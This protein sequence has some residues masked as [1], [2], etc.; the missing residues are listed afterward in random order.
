MRLSLLLLLLLSFP[1]LAQTPDTI[2][3]ATYN[4]LNYPGSTASERNPYF[5]TVMATMHPDILVVQEMTSAAGVQM[6]L[7]EVLNTITPHRFEAAE[8]LDGPDSDNSF[9]YDTSKVVYLGAHYIATELRNIAEYRFA[10][11]QSHDTIR[12]FS[13]HLKSDD[14]PADQDQRSRETALIR[15]RM[16]TV[17]MQAKQTGHSDTS[18]IVAG[19]FNVYQSTEQAYLNLLAK[20][21]WRGPGFF[22]P[23]DR[24]GDWHNNSIYADIHTQSPRVRQFQGGITGGMDDR[25]DFIL[26]DADLL[27]H[28]YVQG[29]YKAYGNDGQH[30]NDSINHLPNLAVPDSVANALHYAA[31]HLPVFADFTFAEHTSEVTTARS[32]ERFNV[33]VSPQ[34]AREE[35]TLNVTSDREQSV[36]IS[37]LNER[38]GLVVREMMTCQIGENTYS[39]QTTG[40]PSGVY[41]YQVESETQTIEGKI[42]VHK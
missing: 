7:D 27:L 16:D 20:I 30:F 14:M 25:F 3:I 12:M 24:P 2:R 4:L 18:F 35:I 32:P 6:F 28:H 29:S 10:T 1:V 22:D 17:S 19:D 42:I 31:D 41:V 8:F 39:I 40:L 36:Q 5:R 38:G 37:I 23:T 33:M 34:P 26:I 15:L 11:R 13:C 21:A 9:F